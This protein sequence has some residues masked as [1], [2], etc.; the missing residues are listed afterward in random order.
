MAGEFLTAVDGLVLLRQND[1]FRHENIYPS[2]RLVLGLQGFK[3]TEAAEEKY[4]YGQNQFLIFK[5][6]QV[7]SSRA[8]GAC[9]EIPFLSISL[10]LDGWIIADLLREAPYLSPGGAC[11]L[12]APLT[13]AADHHI[14]AAFLR[15]VTLLEK[16][17]QI[18]YL[19]PLFI[20]E[21]HY[22]LLLGPL[23]G[24]LR[25]MKVSPTPPIY[26]YMGLG[27]RNNIL[28]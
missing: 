11:D 4:W 21:I 3:Y 26:S 22:R 13:V 16:P 9:P 15:L 27:A 6:D 1:V 23:S 10:N 12:E 25:S 5:G 8:P 17:A 7:G 20:R 24:R 2:P 28:H 18:P 19:A 14:L